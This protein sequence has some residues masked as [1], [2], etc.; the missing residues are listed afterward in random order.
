ML[1]RANALTGD[2]KYLNIAE[3]L[4][5]TIFKYGVLKDKELWLTIVDTNSSSVHRPNAYWWV[6]AYGN[7]YHATGQKKY[8]DDFQKGA[9][10][11]DNHIID[12]KHGDTYTSIDTAGMVK[13][14]TKANRFKTSYHSMEHCLLNCLCLNLWI[15]K[16]LVE[17]YFSINL[18]KKRGCAIPD[19]AGR[20]KR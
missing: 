17:F 5:Q 8:L 2:S 13:D 16:E 7:M 4:S 18:S 19:I 20:Q 6:Q 9:I 10:L 15:N 14:A 11:W 3:K 1:L 12:K